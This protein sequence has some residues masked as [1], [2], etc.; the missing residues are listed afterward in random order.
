MPSIE[1]DDDASLASLAG[2]VAGWDKTLG[3]NVQLPIQIVFTPSGVDSADPAGAVVPI[4]PP[5]EFD[6]LERIPPRRST[7]CARSA[8]STPP[9]R[10]LRDGWP[11]IPA[12]VSS[13]SGRRGI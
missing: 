4:P 13:P 3:E 9:Q 12:A 10:R 6:R 8:P 7:P 2:F 5:Q 11:P 1:H